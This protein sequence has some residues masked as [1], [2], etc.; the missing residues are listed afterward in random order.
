VDYPIYIALGDRNRG[1]AATNGI[2]RNVQIS[3]V[4][5]TGIDPKSGIQITGLPGDDLEGVHLN[6]IRLVFNGGGTADDAARNPKELGTG[7]PEPGKIGVMPAYGLF[8]R[9]VRD[10][11]LDNVHVSFKNDDA[12]PAIICSDVDGLQIDDFKGQTMAGVAPARFEHVTGLDIRN[13]PEL[14]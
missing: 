8:A 9:H 2:V 5:A 6:N 7:Y 13:S 1:P 10:L 4:V 14:Q 11:E 12:R 3:N